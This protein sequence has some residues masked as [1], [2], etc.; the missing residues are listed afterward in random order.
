MDDNTTNI[1]ALQSDG[2]T[3]SNGHAGEN[4]SFASTC[5]DL[6]AASD[7]ALAAEHGPDFPTVPPSTPANA[8]VNEGIQLSGGDSTSH[9]P[10]GLDE[11]DSRVLGVNDDGID[12]DDYF[13][14]IPYEEVHEDLE[15]GESFYESGYQ[16]EYHA[17]LASLARIYWHN[18][19]K[20]GKEALEVAAAVDAKINDAGKDAYQI[21]INILRPQVALPGHGQTISKSSR[22]LGQLMARHK[23]HFVR[24][25]VVVRLRK[26]DAGHFVITDVK[27][28]AM[29]S[30]FEKVATLVKLLSTA[31]G[32]AS[33][34]MN[35]SEGE[36]KAI[37]ACSD[38]LEALPKLKLVTNCP[39]LVE[40]KWGLVAISGYDP[41]SG[42]FANGMPV[43]EVELS[44]AVDLLIGLIQDFKFVTPS[45]R[46]RASASF[47]TPSLVMGGL[48]PGRA[49]LDLGE[50]DKS[51][52]GKGLRHRINA[53]IH[54]EIVHS[55]TPSDGIGKVEEL[56]DKHILD[57]RP[58]VSLDNIRGKIDSPKIES[59]LTEDSYIARI[60]FRSPATV[61]PKRT[62]VML[63]SNKAEVTPDLANRS[64]CVRIEKQPDGYKYKEYSEG[65]ILDHVR[66]N[67]PLYLG[68]VFAVIKNW[69]AF[70]KLST[71]DTRHDFR[72]WAG[73]LDWIVQNLLGAA[74]LLDG[75]Q[76]A[77]ERM[78]SPELTWLRDVALAVMK[79]GRASEWL[80]ASQLLELIDA[81]GLDVPGLKASAS[82]EDEST[83]KTCQQQT[84]KRLG[85]CFNNDDLISVVKLDNL[86]IE[87]RIYTDEQGR[88]HRKE[89]MVYREG[90]DPVEVPF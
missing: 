35:C 28:Q 52:S 88:E 58:F 13:G 4:D 55:A 57:G 76:Q 7:H 12:M 10:H 8:H 24:G 71:G 47:I 53:A 49:A 77:Q 61:D 69:Y 36:A 43:E 73:T 62:Y 70:G 21:L 27:H 89:Y 46:S 65:S 2:I 22:R 74:P 45:D 3:S 31:E 80:I 83:R 82:I 17:H 50:A 15:T 60:A 30:D 29:R 44:K 32:E 25:G 56:F 51:Q 54:G 90:E 1:T 85:R 67:Q 64:S 66:A 5:G 42:I 79:V 26:D 72:A 87:R 11:S 23:T 75:H 37:M 81:A 6:A 19:P 39:V 33:R 84:G 63:T 18:L 48:L 38:F 16:Y 86:C 9:L 68:A 78:T 34:E 14:L 40:K 59:F 41:G 20:E